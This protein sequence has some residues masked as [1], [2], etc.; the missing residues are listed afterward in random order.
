[1]GRALSRGRRL[2][3]GLVARA[4]RLACGALLA[5]SAAAAPAASA[6]PPRPR[7]V[8]QVTVDQLRADLPLRCRDRWGEGGFRRLYEQGVVFPDARYGHANTETVVGH[9]TLATGADP[10]VHGMVGNGWWDRDARTMQQNVDDVRYD[11]AGSAAAA[12]AAP[13]PGR[14]KGKSKGRSPAMMLAP[15]LADSFA[16]AGGGRAK[17]FSVS[18]KDRAAVPMAGRGGKAFWWSDAAG[19]FLSS[20]FHYPDGR[21]PAWA[22]AWNARREADLYDGRSWTLLLPPSGYRFAAKDDQPWESP[23]PGIGRTF[24][25][26]YDRAALKD[27][28]SPALAASPFGDELVVSFVRALMEAEDVGRDDVVDYV[29]VSL[30]STDYI[31]HR[32]GPDSL[33]MEDQ[34]LRVDRVLAALLEAADDAAGRGRT[35]VVLSADHG[36]G[37]PVE[38]ERAEGHDA[39]RIVLSQVEASAPVRALEKRFGGPLVA[40]NS[41]PFVYLDDAALKR[42]GVDPLRVADALAAEIA[43]T[44][45]VAAVLTRAQLEGRAPLH[46]RDGE[47]GVDVLRAVRRSFHPQRSGDLYVVAKPGWQIAHEGPGTLPYATGHGTPWSYDSEVPLVFAGAGL[48]A[49][50]IAGPADATDVAPTVAA[51]AGVPAP[52]KATGHP[53]LVFA[54]P[55]DGQR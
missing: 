37:E 7:L 40:Q 5:V 38:E 44:L 15:T 23:P 22:T 3:A 20:T 10:S 35:L 9:A 30:S 1:M 2:P 47:A 18:W 48:P 33:E 29:S 21:L 26:R 4:A 53:L 45:G 42:R 19:E 31:G 41:P 12:A 55:A 43:K 51:L 54:K 28:Y 14:G 50:T 16:E 8:L 27:G 24:P 39:G 34:V 6:P 46:M 52:A 13:T 17:V 11:V 32:F 25:H 49:R 36:V